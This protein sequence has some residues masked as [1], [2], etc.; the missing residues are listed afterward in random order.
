MYERVFLF[1]MAGPTLDFLR[2][3][4]ESLPN[5]RRFLEQGAWGRLRGRPQPGSPQSFG[6]LLTGRSPGATGLFDTFTFAAGGYVRAQS[7]ARPVEHARLH[8]L[9]SEQ[10]RRVGVLNVPL[11]A[12]LRPVSGFVVSGDEGVG[13]DF[14]YPP[15][16]RDAL[17]ADG[18]AVPFGA[19]YA[20]GREREF[21][22]HALAVLAMRR[23]AA[24][25]LFGDGHWQFGMLTLHLYGELLHAFWKFYDERHPAHRP[26]AAAFGGRDPLLEAL[27]GVDRLLGE[28]VALAGPRGLVVFLGAWG[29]R[30]VHS[31]V[32]LNTA[33]ARSG[34]LRFTS[35]PRTRL[36]RALFRAGVTSASAER[37]AHRLDLWKLFHYRMARAD[38]AKVTGATFLSHHDVDWSR[39]RAVAMGGLGQVY[40]NVRGHRPQG[41]IPPERCVAERERIRS[42]LAGLRDPRTGDPM[43]ERVHTRDELYRGERVTDA[44]DL[45]VEWRPGYAGDGGFSGAGRLVT[46]SPPHLSSDHSTESA[47]LALGADVRQ[48]ELSAALEDVAPTVLH[49]LGAALPAG[50]DGVVLPLSAGG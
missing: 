25:R 38:R 44:P 29:H 27:Q 23:R 30:L 3:R 12:P 46:P 7:D 6:A 42:L 21:A 16:V 17:G 13:E 22:D 50:L 32:H 33:L 15:E 1:E 8:E 24:L 43:V 11:T 2:A 20:E 14:A 40:L 39:T 49:A 37:L 4:Q 34:D 9:L 41:V 18:Y 31:R 35:G 28:I 45:V 19:S 5:I 48:G 47:L 26:A 10:G 36:K